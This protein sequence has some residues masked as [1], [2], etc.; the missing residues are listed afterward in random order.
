VVGG[1]DHL[2]DH[3]P[4]A[5]RREILCVLVQTQNNEEDRAT[6]M[7]DNDVLCQLLL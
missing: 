6:T 3:L 2:F 1:G 5:I 4:H 7:I